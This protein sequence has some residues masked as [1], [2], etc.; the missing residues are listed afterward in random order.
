MSFWCQHIYSYCWWSANIF[1][2]PKPQLHVHD[3]KEQEKTEDIRVLSFPVHSPR[4]MLLVLVVLGLV[5]SYSI[6]DD[7]I[8]KSVDELQD[9]VYLIQENSLKQKVNLQLF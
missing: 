8:V 3:G 4:R 6:V 5:V 7:K 2:Q 9:F 1:W